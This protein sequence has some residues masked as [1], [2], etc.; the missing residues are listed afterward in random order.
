MMG[1][2]VQTQTVQLATGANQFEL[3]LQALPAGTYLLRIAT[4]K[5]GAAVKVV[6]Q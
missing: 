2:L 4:D 6:K 1:E 5:T 3:S